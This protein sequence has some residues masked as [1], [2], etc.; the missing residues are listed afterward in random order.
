MAQLLQGLTPLSTDVLETLLR[1]LYREEISCPLTSEGLALIGLQY[2]QEPILGA[3]RALDAKAITAVLVCVIAER[4]NSTRQ[5]ES[6]PE[7]SD[8]LISF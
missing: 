8:S 7:P 2:C 4:R 1:H 6:R 5:T 3:L